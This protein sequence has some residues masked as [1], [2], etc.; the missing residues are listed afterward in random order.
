S[1][2]GR[3]AQ[4]GANLSAGAA[5]AAAFSSRHDGGLPGPSEQGLQQFQLPLFQAR[6]T[7]KLPGARC[8]FCLAH[9]RSRVSARRN[10][11]AQPVRGA[12][13]H[14]R[15]AH[16]CRDP[17]PRWG[18]G[19]ADMSQAFDPVAIPLDGLRLIEASAGT[20]KTFSL[21]GLYLRLIVEQDA[22][23]REILVMTFT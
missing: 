8:L 23:V 15:C 22:S 10:R 9:W 5:V 20:G 2:A 19:D 12:G 1:G 17:A 11:G 4:A 3:V 7:S 21:A 6:P 13:T 16:G 14:H 18:N